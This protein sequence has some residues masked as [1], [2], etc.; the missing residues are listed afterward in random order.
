MK[1]IPRLVS[2]K[3]KAVNYILDTSNGDGSF[4]PIEEGFFFY[5]LPWT[6]TVAGETAAA[7][8]VCQWV[9]DNM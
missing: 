9:R 8:S 5:R 7:A 6:F 3:R 4:G 1:L 2:V